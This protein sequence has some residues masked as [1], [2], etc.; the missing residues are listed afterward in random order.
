[1]KLLVKGPSRFSLLEAKLW[2]NKAK[3]K[4]IKAAKMVKLIKTCDQYP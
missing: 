4:N 3:T 1:M 2:H